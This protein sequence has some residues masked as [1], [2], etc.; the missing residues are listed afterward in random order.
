MKK[1]FKDT[2]AGKLVLEKIPEAAKLVGNFLPDNGLLGVVKNLIAG[3]DI[4]PEERKALM[5]E[6]HRFE[7]EM[8]SLEIKDRESAR[9]R[10]VEV[11]KTGGPDLLMKCAGFTAL[12]TFILM[13]VAVIFTFPGSSN[14]LF[15]QLMGIIEGVAMTIFAYYFGTSK[16]SSDKTKLL[17]NGKK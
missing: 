16:G 13:V 4:P 5:E 17:A 10:E 7:A 8:Y 6:M 15:H 14:S 1:P 12:S 11:A 3:A 2:A 9:T